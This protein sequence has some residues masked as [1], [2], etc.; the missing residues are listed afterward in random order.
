MRIIQITILIP[1]MLW[2]GSKLKGHS[3]F[4]IIFLSLCHLI[5]LWSCGLESPAIVYQKFLPPR[6]GEC[7]NADFL[8]TPKGRGASHSR[9]SRR[10]VR[11]IVRREVVRGSFERADEIRTQSKNA[12]PVG[13]RERRK[14]AF[15]DP[16]RQASH[17]V[18]PAF[19]DQT[20]KVPAREL[21]HV[22]LLGELRPL[23]N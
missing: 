22:A 9:R 2:S 17:R 6:K 11:Q 13:H 4:P 7:R 3:P 10:R 14:I 12:T 16:M 21:A 23:A 20:D 19:A 18:P 15:P 1:L 8:E 5:L